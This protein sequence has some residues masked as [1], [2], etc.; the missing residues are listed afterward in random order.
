MFSLA[1]FGC[2]PS[3]Q[4]EFQKEGE[5]ISR[6][7]LSDLQKIQNTEEL[8]KNQ[9]LLKKRFSDLVDLMIAAREFQEEHQEEIEPAVFDERFNELIV[10]ELSRIYQMERGRE[11]IEKAQREPMN[12]LDLFERKLKSRLSKY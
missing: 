5:S 2:A 12:R 8:I 10:I 11:L 1:L 7:L 4:K 9:P 3:S 6:Q